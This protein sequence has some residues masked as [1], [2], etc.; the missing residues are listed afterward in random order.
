MVVNGG[1]FV[2]HEPGDGSG[3]GG[4]LEGVGEKRVAG[5]SGSRVSA[6]GD[7]WGE[8]APEG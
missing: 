8:F 4:A 6:N 1:V 3:V 7:N 2:A 5:T